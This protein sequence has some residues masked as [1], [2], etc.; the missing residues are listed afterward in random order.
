[1]IDQLGSTY[2]R[3]PS[4]DPAMRDLQRKPVAQAD[5]QP[6]GQSTNQN[7]RSWFRSAPVAPPPD[8]TEIRAEL[9]DMV[10]RLNHRSH[11]FSENVRFELESG[12]RQLA[13][14]MKSEDEIINRYT[15]GEI[16]DLE[17]SLYHMS[18]F[19]FSLEG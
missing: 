6:T 17:R 10:D 7:K 13:I 3:Y 11:Q 14:V 2:N 5:Q 1:M 18:G 19:Q 16:M 9:D 15:P 8:L 12:N 4:L